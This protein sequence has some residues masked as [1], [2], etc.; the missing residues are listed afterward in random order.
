MLLKTAVI[1][2]LFSALVSAQ[3][4]PAGDGFYQAIRQD[5]LAALRALVRDEGSTPRT[6]RDRRR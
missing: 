6:R 3:A 2:V 4:P 5:D 1:L